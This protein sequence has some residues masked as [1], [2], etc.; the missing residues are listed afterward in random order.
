VFNEEIN[1]SFGYPKS[2]TCGTCEQFKIKLQSDF[3]ENSSVQSS[4]KSICPQ[5]KNSIPTF[6]S[7]QKWL[8]KMC[9]Y[10]LLHSIFSKI[11]PFHLPVGDLFYMHQLWL[12]VFGVHSWGAQLWQ[13]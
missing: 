7:T 2:D 11:Y 1:L 12:Y 4:V 5:Q 13:Q 10:I 6:T 8:R 9:M 3:S